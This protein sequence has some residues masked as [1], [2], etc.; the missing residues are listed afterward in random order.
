LIREGKYKNVVV[1]GGDILTR[2]VVTGFHAFNSV[3]KQVCRPYDEA[4][5]G[6][7]LGEGCGA[8]LLTSE[9]TAT[10]QPRIEVAGGAISSDANHISAPS[11][12]GD[13]LYLA[14]RSAMYEAKVNAD[15]IGFVNGHGTGTVYNDEMES[16]AFALAGVDGL[17]V[18]A[19]KPYFG[20]TLGAA[21]VIETIVSAHA[22]R[23]ETVYGTPNF[24]RAGT[25]HILNVSPQNRK[26]EAGVCLKTAS[27]FGGSN[28]AIILR[29][30]SN[31]NSELGGNHTVNAILG[32][33]IRCT[34]SVR[35]TPDNR[36]FG[37]MIRERFKSLESPDMK[38]FR[39]DNLS[40]LAYVAAGELLRNSG[41]GEKYRPDEIG[42][43]LANRS[44]SLDT[45]I[46]HC[47]QIEQNG[48]EVSPAVFVYTLPNVAAGEMS[49]RHKIQ[50]ETT[51]F[52]EN[53][54]D[55][56]FVEQY[57]HMLLHRK[58]L[59]AVIYGR[60]ELL[61]ENFGAEM[62]LLETK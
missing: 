24:D 54:S 45:D 32:S 52:I 49:I 34:A 50:G 48:D 35:I 12:T 2:F 36:T 31:T 56:G 29:K 7:T 57:A 19:L 41:I 5:D 22:I 61:G 33:N 39:M 62:T 30:D 55:R 18:S 14:I 53:N 28:A 16:K 38:F 44:A 58:Y 46:R 21:G 17:P 15:E 60:C 51:F 42:I 43:I 6:L 10:A 9:L 13:G 26:T 25:S 8:I 23:T 1:A 27:G 47:E 3:S 40:K 59:K 11:R 20:H 4:R 37:E